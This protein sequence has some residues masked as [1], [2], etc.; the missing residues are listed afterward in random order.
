LDERAR[1]VVIGGGVTGCSVAYHLAAAGCTDVILL[2]KG[3]LTSG[4]TMHAAGL[5]TM[6]NPSPTMMRFRRYSIELYRSLGVFEGV[7][8]IRIAS[9]RPRLMEFQRGVSRA[10]GIGLEAH[11]LGP[12]ETLERLPA[13]SPKDLLGS[14]WMP[15]DGFLDPHGVTHALA[16]AAAAAGVR[17]RTGERVTAIEL[18]PGREVR[19]VRTE[20]GR[21][22]TETVVNAAG[23]WAPRVAAMIGVHVPSTPVDHQH[24]AVAAVPGDALPRDMPCF[25]DPDNLVY[26]KSEAG[27]IL[28]GGYEGDPVAR[29]IDGVP[30][31]HGGASSPADHERFR[32]LMQGAIRRFPFLEGAGLVRLVCHPDAMTPDAN[33]LLGPVPEV[34]GFWMAAGLSLNGFGAAGGMGRTLAGWITDDDTDWDVTA[35]RPWR[36]GRV[37]EDVRWVSELSRET[38]RYYYLQ[39]YPFDQDEWGRPRRLSPLHGPLQDAGAVFGP[40][41]G[42]ERADHVDPGRPWRRAGAEQRSYGYTR[43]PW[44]ERVGTEHRAVRE[45]VGLFDLSS[46]GKIELRGPGAL[47][48]LE[49]VATATIDRPIGSVIYTT[50]LDAGGGIVSEVTITRLEEDRFRVATGAA[51]V[52]ADLGWLRMHARGEP[53]EIADVTEDL[54]VIGVWGARAPALLEAL[55]A[56]G[57]RPFAA[58]PVAIGATSVLMVGLCFPGGPGWELWMPAEGAVQVWETLALAGGAV[59]AE[60]CGYR[61]LEGLR[62]EAGRRAMGTDLTAREDPITAGLE[63]TVRAD[64]GFIGA[65]ALAARPREERLRFLGLGEGEYVAAYGGEALRRGD[66]IVGR[67][68]ASAFGY[69]MGHHLGTA[70]LPIDVMPGD[71]LWVDVFDARV[72]VL[73]VDDPP[74]KV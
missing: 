42:W 34:R 21:I 6:F 48:L 11:V 16:A 2:E 41:H 70:V 32:P 20:G 54:A 49:R 13:A 57:A 61:C 43:P 7:G 26:G 55:D 38:Y 64:P 65:D 56:V 35:Y 8:S 33:P 73:V 28:F 46:F 36:F 60:P 23:I 3:E 50:F 12:E 17:V 22:E 25:R 72:P 9:S 63:A 74:M 1:V 68:R 5:V 27:G 47:A 58:Q 44:F 39:R 45:G 69:S 52:D 29:W 4:S 30:W 14:V 51:A 31:T 40:K 62:L 24:A 37:H 59:G 67:L 66:A 18:G 10:A 19:A 15:Q 71:R 53:V